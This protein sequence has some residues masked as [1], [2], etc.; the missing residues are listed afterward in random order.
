M[1]DFNL[2]ELGGVSVIVLVFGIVE[3]SKHFGLGGKACQIVAWRLA[4]SL[5]CLPRKQATRCRF[6]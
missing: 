6:A 4:G 3:A 5:T 1:P 2:F